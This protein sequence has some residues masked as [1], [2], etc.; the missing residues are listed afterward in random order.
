MTEDK[1][2]SENDFAYFLRF[3]SED[4]V[5]EKLITRFASLEQFRH[6]FMSMTPDGLC[7]K[8]VKCQ[9]I[10]GT[11]EEAR[12]SHGKEMCPNPTSFQILEKLKIIY[13]CEHND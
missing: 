5:T 4:I 3:P 8:C 10:V 2:S 11:Y 7:W 13:K 6:A 9:Y 1:E 12:D